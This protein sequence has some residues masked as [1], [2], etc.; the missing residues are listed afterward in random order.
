MSGVWR[1]RRVL[2]CAVAC[3]CG[4]EPLVVETACD[5]ASPGDLVITEVHANP[6]GADGDGEYI[7]LFNPTRSSVD[8]DGWTV[9]AGRTDAGASKGHRLVG[10]VIGAG[11]YVVI[12]NAPAD[13]PPA[14]VD[15]GYGNGLGSLRNSDGTISIDCGETL[16][17]RVDYESSTDGRAIELDGEIHPNHELNDDPSRWCTTPEDAA[18]PIWGANFGTPG[19]SNNP[20][21]VDPP[22]GSC[23]EGEEWRIPVQ[24][25]P[26]DVE[27]TEWMANPEGLDAELEWVEILFGADADLRGFQL[28]PDPDSLRVAID[29]ES[30]FP[31]DAGSRVVFGAS[32]GAALRVD[33]ELGFSLGNSGP[34]RIVAAVGDRVL[35]EVAYDRTTESVSWQV[36][37]EGQ[38][39][40]AEADQEYQPGRF[41]SPGEPNPAC[42]P[43]L[44]DGMCFGEGGVPRAIESALAGEVFITEWMAD[45][46]AVE[47]RKGEWVEVRFDAAADLNGLILSDRAGA[48]TTIE[49]EACLPVGPGTH[50]VWARELDPSL[51]G[52]IANAR[53]EL[54]LSLNNRDETLTLSGDG[55]VLDTI[56]YADSDKGVAIQTD[57][58]GMVC[59]AMIPYG[60]GNLGTPGLANPWCM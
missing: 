6:D 37:S 3:G 22:A 11:D 7:E 24:P 17:D 15:Y 32:P 18:D 31:V 8:V 35:D 19:A 13:S 59:S 43:L 34:R 20:C 53:I 45:P 42:P 60:D 44:E 14:H 23:L 4:Q 40:L 29:G 52:G 39:C 54:S 12:G 46:A 2:W 27:I 55:G 26:E 1:W 33:A 57:H 56:S 50:V 48:A 51:N 36:D 25:Q 16:I 21:T 58:S 30:C 41:G 49:D 47:N 10:L 38:T 5:D 9:T 28:G